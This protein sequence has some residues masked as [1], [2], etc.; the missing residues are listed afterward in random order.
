II[1]AEPKAYIIEN[2]EDIEKIIE[3]LTKI[4]NPRNPSITDYL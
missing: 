1:K 2:I 4:K 3:S